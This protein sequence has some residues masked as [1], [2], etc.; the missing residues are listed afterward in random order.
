MKV[1][2]IVSVVVGSMILTAVLDA[3]AFLWWQSMLAV[4]SVCM[5]AIGAR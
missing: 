4:M 3:H 1:F 5:I 2:M